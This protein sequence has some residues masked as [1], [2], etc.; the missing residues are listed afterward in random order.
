MNFPM[1]FQ[2]DVGKPDPYNCTESLAW[3]PLIHQHERGPVFTAKCRLTAVPSAAARTNFASLGRRGRSLGR[4]AVYGGGHQ[5][6]AVGGASF[7][8]RI[9]AP[10]ARGAHATG[11]AR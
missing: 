11:R 6:V 5:V 4:R 8:P 9:V 2:A 1:P 10:A 7:D 3:S